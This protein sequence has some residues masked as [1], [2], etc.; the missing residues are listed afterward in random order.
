[1]PNRNN[2]DNDN[3]KLHVLLRLKMET[4]VVRLLSA[5]FGEEKRRRAIVCCN[6]NSVHTS[7]AQ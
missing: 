7:S 5:V 3:D 4:L 2:D 6:V 1:M